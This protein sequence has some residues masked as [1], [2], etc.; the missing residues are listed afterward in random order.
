MLAA[1]TVSKLI[2]ESDT[3]YGWLEA[4]TGGVGG[5]QN[6]NCIRCSRSLSSQDVPQRL[7]ISYVQNLPFGQGQRF[8]SG[9]HGLAGKLVSGWGVDGITTFQSGFP[10]KLGTSV[11]LTNSFG[12]GSRPNVVPGCKSTL[13]GSAQERLTRW[14]NTGCYT[15]PPAFTFGNEARV[16][17]VLRTHG[18]NNF[19]A[20]LFKN[21]TFGPRERLG[22]QFRAEF[23]NLFNR[24]QFGPPGT[25]LGN[26]QF[27][28]VS[29]QVNNPRLMQFALKFLF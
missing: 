12:G 10:L 20:A 9:A 19:D 29:S 8:L 2:A 16:D 6:W 28:V 5:I 21:T 22:V 27:S 15:Q 17:P 13:P 1:Y 7:V 23:F 14:F 3:Q 26:P 11:N 25:T 24:A 18:I 4:A